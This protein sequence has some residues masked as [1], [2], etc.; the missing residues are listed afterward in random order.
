[1][2]IAILYVQITRTTIQLNPSPP[3]KKYILSIWKLMYI[4]TPNVGTL[5]VKH[6]RTVRNKV[7]QELFPKKCLDFGSDSSTR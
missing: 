2:L 6:A 1:M 4:G 3:P 7:V 5:K